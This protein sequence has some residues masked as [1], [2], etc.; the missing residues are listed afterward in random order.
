MPSRDYYLTYNDTEE[1]SGDVN[2][3]EQIIIESDPNFSGLNDS[4]T[5]AANATAAPPLRPA[6]AYINFLAETAVLLGAEKEF[7]KQEAKDIFAFE[8]MLAR[9][10]NI[11]SVNNAK[12]MF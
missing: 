10:R 1:P 3:K 11:C 12:I 2:L 5:T 9:V 4:E 7:A 8:S 6:E